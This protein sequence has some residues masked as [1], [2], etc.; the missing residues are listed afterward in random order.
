MAE[1][2]TSDMIAGLFSLS[3]S[4]GIR[5][6]IKVGPVT[7]DSKRN[8]DAVSDFRIQELGRGTIAN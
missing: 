5:S 4:A 3:A 6:R 1:P 2:F 8:G 7:P